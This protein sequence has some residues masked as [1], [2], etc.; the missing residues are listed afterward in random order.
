MRFDKAF[1]QKNKKK[2]PNAEDALKKFNEHPVLARRLAGMWRLPELRR[3]I[4]APSENPYYSQMI[5]ANISL[6][7]IHCFAKYE[8]FES[9]QIKKERKYFSRHFYPDAR[10]S[11]VQQETRSN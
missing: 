9:A 8:D 10:F 6:E 1:I 3:E 11:L 2:F 5:E 7:D 4:H